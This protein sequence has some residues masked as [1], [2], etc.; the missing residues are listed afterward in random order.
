M[1]EKLQAVEK[2]TYLTLYVFQ[3][4]KILKGKYPP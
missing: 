2:S 1:S 3:L 4:N